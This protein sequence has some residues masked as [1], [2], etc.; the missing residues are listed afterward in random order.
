MLITRAS[1]FVK[2]K[3]RDLLGDLKRFSYTES[4]VMNVGL[5]FLNNFFISLF[6]NSICLSFFL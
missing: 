6:L 2:L 4:H 5:R 3:R 1:P